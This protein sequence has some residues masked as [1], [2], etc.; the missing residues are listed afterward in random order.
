MTSGCASCGGVAETVVSRAD[1]HGR[2][3]VPVICDGCGLIHNDPIPSEAELEAFYRRDYRQ[4]YKG[5]AEPRPRQVWRNHNR[6]QAH[7]LAFRDIYAKGGRWLDLGAGSGEFTFLARKIGADIAAIEPN[8]AYAAYCRATLDLDVQTARLEDSDF[9]PGSFDLIRLSHVLEHMRDPVASLST[10]RDWLAPGGL[11]YIEVPDIERDA[12]NKLRGRLFHYGHIFNFNPLTLR[13]V[14]ARAGLVEL[15]QTAARSAGT[16]G[17]FFTAGEGGL[18]SD[19]A[20]A[21]NASRMRAAITDHYARRVPLPEEGS[22]TL[23]F[24]RTIAARARE[25]YAGRKLNSPRRI[26]EDSASRLI[27]RMQQG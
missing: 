26:A 16:C 18:A 15:P 11:I 7:F 2:P 27:A 6:L 1:R 14:A 3:L 5:A 22:A 24:L 10:L 8:E 23:R 4:D 17:A 13:Q 19:A 21:A 12:R 9:A 25:A 20:L